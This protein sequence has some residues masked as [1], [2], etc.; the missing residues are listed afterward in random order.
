MSPEA[1]PEAILPRAFY[2]RDA[3]EVAHDLI[4]RWLRMDAVT[5]RITETEAY[6]V[7]DSAC[8]GNR[9]QTPRTAAM[10]GPPGH[11]YVYVC[12]G[13]HQMLNIA[14]GPENTP[15]AVL[16][17]ACA[18]VEGIDVIAARR[19]GKRGP[20]ALTGPGKIGAALAL[21]LTWNHHPL[22]E[23]GGLELLHG[24][25]ASDIA[26]GPRVGIDYAD[27]A[28]VAAPWRIAEGGS[29]WVSVRKTLR[30]LQ[31]GDR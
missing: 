11:V 2:A 28:D 9:G 24:E 30:P 20:V 13:I 19:G 27:P 25:P 16:I 21:D 1:G 31:P 15:Q 23:A 17:R 7:G 18:P 5:L 3:L 6:R 4:G 22:F 10:F 26:V 12:Y 14:T 8:H 29:K